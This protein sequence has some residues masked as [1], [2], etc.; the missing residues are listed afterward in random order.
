MK[1]ALLLVILVCGLAVG[2]AAAQATRNA[3]RGPAPADAP[4]ITD[5]SSHL[6]AITSSFTGTELLLFGAIDEPGDIIVV[7]RGPVSNA[8]VRRKGR[9]LGLWLTERSVSFDGVPGYYAVVSNKPLEEIA[10]EPLLQRLQIGTDNL[11]FRHLGGEPPPDMADF[12]RAII[13]QKIREGLYHEAVDAIDFLGPKLFRTEL[14]FPSTV[15]VGTYRAEIY[16]IRN[17][18]IVAAQSTPLF[19]DKHGIEQQVFDFS[20]QEPGVYGMVAVLLAVLAGWAAAIA[21]RKR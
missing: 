10:P 8:V 14:S 3:P 18:R 6:I 1:A 19:I 9:T 21:F 7:V 12:R 16:L 4:L 2:E 5:L 13:R 15:P 17:D 20:R 11:R